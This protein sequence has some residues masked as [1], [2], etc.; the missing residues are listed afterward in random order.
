ML[1]F[2]NTFGVKAIMVVPVFSRGEFWGIVTLQDHVNDRYFDDAFSD[3]LC[4]AARLCASFVIRAERM[5]ITEKALAAMEH[6]KRMTEILNESAVMFLSQHE[7]SFE[8]IMTDGL[9]LIADEL[10]LDRVWVA[11]NFTMPDGLYASQIYR[12]DRESGGTTMPTAGL[13]ALSYTK[14]V[15]GWEELLANGECINSPINLLPEAAVLKPFGI[16]SVFV[17]PVFISGVFWGAVIFEDRRAERYF[18]DDSADMMKSAALLCANTVLINEK[19]QSAKNAGKKLKLREK[20]LSALNVMSVALLMHNVESF[21][22][23]LSKGLRL[24]KDAAGIDRVAIYRRLDG[25]SQSGR[26]RLGQIYL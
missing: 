7:K 15:P 23:V 3:L 13:E 20:M 21:D 11:R 17:A 10:D 22:V 1:D 25:K 8:D 12:W 9:R 18:D 5:L 19:T 4:T 24:I 16:V 6:S 2:V 26:M 14:H